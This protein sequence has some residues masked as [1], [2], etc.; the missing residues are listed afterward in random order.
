L[1]KKA[2]AAMACWPEDNIFE[3][4]DSLKIKKVDVDAIVLKLKG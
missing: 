4:L 3:M 2:L 1:G